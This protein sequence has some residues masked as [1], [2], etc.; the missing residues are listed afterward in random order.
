MNATMQRLPASHRGACMVAV[1]PDVLVVRRT[2]DSADPETT[3][4]T[5]AKEQPLQAGV[6]RLGGHGAQRGAAE[7]DGERPDGAATDWPGRA[8]GIRAP[9]AGETPLSWAEAAIALGKKRL[10]D[11]DGFDDVDTWPPCRRIVPAGTWG[12]FAPGLR[13]AQPFDGLM[14]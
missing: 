13:Q 3:G 14:P 2:P 5:R 8:Y 6:N 9:E 12:I 11:L 1:L 7:G 10:D 4:A